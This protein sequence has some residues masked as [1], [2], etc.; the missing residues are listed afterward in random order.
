MRRDGKR[1]FLAG[2]LAAGAGLQLP[3]KLG[4]VI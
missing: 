4:K 2:G 3:L 1:S